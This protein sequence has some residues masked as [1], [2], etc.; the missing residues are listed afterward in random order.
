MLKDTILGLKEVSVD[1]VPVLSFYPEDDR[2]I[3]EK[4]II[5]PLRKLYPDFIDYF[6]IV[7]QKGKNL[8][9]R[10]TH[11]FSFAFNELKFG[12]VIIIGSDTPHLQPRTIKQSINTLEKKNEYAIIGPSQNGGFYLLGHNQ[13]F[14]KTIGSI[15]QRRSSYG[16]LGD[17]M[18][19][20]F[21][22]NRVHILPE[23][24]DVDTFDN[25]KTVRTIIKLLSFSSSEELGY[26]FPQY[27]HEMLSSIDETSWD[28]LK[29]S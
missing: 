23:V 2:E 29:S 12:S 28:Q 24:T 26:Y 27:T 17:A 21:T 15:F 16:E 5:H 11:A 19:L 6:I 7:S 8:S 9:E 20:L 14:I 1:F 18:N 10:F 25:L 22:R 4:L 13:P 3:L